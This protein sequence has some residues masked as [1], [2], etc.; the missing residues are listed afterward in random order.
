MIF[1][2]RNRTSGVALVEFSLVATLLLL[3][4]AGAGDFGRI[5]TEAIAVKAGT[6]TAA[7]YGS[8]RFARSGDAAGMQAKA[9]ADASDAGTVT[10]TAAQYCTCPAGN[11]TANWNAIPCAEF[12]ATTCNNAYG[13]PRAYIQVNATKD[14]TTVIKMPGI[15]YS[16]TIDQT[17][18]M[19][20]R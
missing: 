18:W 7:M 19:R 8:Q 13:S 9:E 15:P 3:L 10:V 16:T 17:T 12:S 5:F 4:A 14:F 20:V 6:A 11:G 2:E 1:R